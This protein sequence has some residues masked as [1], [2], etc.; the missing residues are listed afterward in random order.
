MFHRNFGIP[1]LL[2]GMYAVAGTV[3]IATGQNLPPAEQPYI[4]RATD[5]VRQ[6]VAPVALYPDAL[7]AQLLTASTYPSEVTAAAAWEDAGNPPQAIDAQPWDASVKGVAHYPA[8][9]HYMAANG[10]WMNELGDVFLNQRADVMA[11]VQ[12]LRGEALAA[13]TLRNT[14]QQTIVN[15][16]GYIQIIPADP[17]QIYAPIYD[18]QTI[19][20]PP[21]YVAGQPYPVY[22]NFCPPEYVGDWL[23]C[24][25]DWYDG[26]IYFGLWGRDRPW[27]HRYRGG[28]HHY[29]DDRPGI[30]R[31]GH[32]RDDLG[33][34]I[35]AE[36]SVWM[37]DTHRPLPVHVAG[38]VP[39]AVIARP[40]RGYAP[41]ETLIN[42]R[43]L[44]FPRGPEVLRQSE[45]GQASR[46]HAFAPAP[47]RRAPEVVRQ[48]VHFA[49][50]HYSPPPEARS[51]APSRGGAMRGYEG[52][53]AASRSASRGAASRGRR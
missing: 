34:P 3:L 4:L 15:L 47:V 51:S 5:Q 12:S 42:N 17:S 20:S 25:V 53:G 33:R 35:N 45:R 37:R 7:L 1:V 9:L 48:P 11:A 18:P 10:P 36:A 32:F 23:N 50:T 13:G 16:D 38:P 29:L 2:A 21:I 39:R 30:Y 41:R 19:Y 44:A 6:L 8:V 22:E 14:P 52:G 28:I 46:E 40:E 43:S 49:P 24:D 26:A 31:P 27:W